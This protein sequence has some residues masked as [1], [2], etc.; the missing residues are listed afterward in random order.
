MAGSP[1]GQGLPYRADTAP[2]DTVTADTVTADTVTASAAPTHAPTLTNPVGGT[3]P[4]LAST[5]TV[6][7]SGPGD[8]TRPGPPAPRAAG[9]GRPGE[10]V[11]H[12]PGVPVTTAADR[13]GPTAEEVWRTG[14]PGGKP[15]RKGWR[16]RLIG[17]ALTVALFIASIVVIY[18]RVHHAPFGV[19]GV[20]ITGQAQHGC[21]VDVTGRI[22]TS[23]AAGTLSYEWT[24][25][26]QAGQPQA[27]S[28]TVAA[29]Q[30]SVYVTA[31]VEGQ[32]SGTLSQTATLRV[33]APGQ[34]SATAHVVL[35]C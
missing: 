29:G 10:L 31:E 16:R 15:R 19:S 21:T 23:G 20:V 3:A 27:E 34:G 6:A 12:G 33:L 2:A 32:G 4:A 25:Q 9:G 22:S 11:R 24:F 5:Q 14:L 35:S 7:G 18:A 17:P 26:P 30:T 28:Q 8:A 1:D 13:T